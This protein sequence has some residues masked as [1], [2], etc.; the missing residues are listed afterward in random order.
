M[1]VLDIDNPKSCKECPLCVHES[2][3]VDQRDSANHWIYV[4]T[5]SGLDHKD[6]FC[7]IMAEITEEEHKRLN[8]LDTYHGRP[9]A[10]WDECQRLRNKA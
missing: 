9:H 3:C 7:P 8:I 2:S 4:R 6:W 5:I 10:S 1:V